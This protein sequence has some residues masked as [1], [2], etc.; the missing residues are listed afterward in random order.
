MAKQGLGLAR[1]SIV[2][3]N[4]EC[5]SV[6]VKGRDRWAL[7]ALMSAG[8]R[9]CTPISNPAPRL[10]AYVFNLRALGV[11]I[12]TVHERHEGLFAGTHARY[13]LRCQIVPLDGETSA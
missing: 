10:S 4:G 11:P 7:E 5:L 3:P 12:E 9:G 8:T 6:S 1:Y 2:Y 13:V